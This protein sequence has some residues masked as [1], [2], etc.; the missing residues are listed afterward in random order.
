M[1]TGLHAFA[2]DAERAGRLADAL[3]VPLRLIDSH[4]FPDGET[5]VTVQG[6][7]RRVLVY[8]SLDRPNAKLFPLAQACDAWRR[9]GAERLVLVAP[10]LAYLRQDAVFAPGQSLSRDV[11]GRLLGE[12]F[13]RVVTVEPHLHRT[14]DLSAVFGV[15]T[16]VLPAAAELA[17]ALTAAP[18]LLVVGPDAESQ[19]WTA[20]LAGLMGA[21]SAT[22]LKI[23]RGDA[24]VEL[25]LDDAVRVAGRPVVLVDDICSSGATLIGAVEELKRRGAGRIV[26][27]VVHALF[28][29]ETEARLRAAGADDILSAESCPHPSNRIPL[30]ALLAQ[31]L[32]QELAP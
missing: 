6:A 26:V 28:S 5:L 17:A 3:G 22:F 12:R 2:E 25:A 21:S 4:A 16:T 11:I 29:E 1:S 15:E 18:D 8:R 9:A 7:D 14:G 30:T 13:D 19:A 32:V 10:Y 20:R 27:A 31:A 24:D 23:R